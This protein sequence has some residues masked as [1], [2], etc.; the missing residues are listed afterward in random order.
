[1]TKQPK[2]ADLRAMIKEYKL[3]QGDVAQYL[4]N[5]SGRGGEAGEPLTA[6]GLR[7]RLDKELTEDEE[8]EIRQ[9]I[10]AAFAEHYGIV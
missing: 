3:T 8:A 2:N 9:A 1:M 6:A 10:S 7:R 5:N 4:K